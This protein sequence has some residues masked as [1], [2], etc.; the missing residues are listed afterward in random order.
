M[1]K[2]IPN[3]PLSYKILYGAEMLTLYL[4]Q[5]TRGP[6]WPAK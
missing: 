1:K 5:A 4:V 2:V 6:S 3:K